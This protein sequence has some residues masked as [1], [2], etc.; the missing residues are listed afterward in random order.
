MSSTTTSPDES[1][2][3]SG[4]PNHQPRTSQP[5]CRWF[6]SGSISVS[7]GARYYEK[8]KIGVWVSLIHFDNDTEIL[9][10]TTQSVVHPALIGA[11]RTLA[12][13]IHVDT[14]KY[15]SSSPELITPMLARRGIDEET[16]SPLEFKYWKTLFWFGRRYRV[17][18][19]L[20]ENLKHDGLLK[21]DTLLVKQFAAILEARRK[22]QELKA[23][24]G[25]R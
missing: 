7:A 25:L 13:L 24:F 22:L 16:V 17:K 10:G 2:P 12:A 6:S 19:S 14:V 3:S 8:L 15:Y 20:D 18:W 9:C 11:A 21:D 4:K 23:S 5:K 1:E